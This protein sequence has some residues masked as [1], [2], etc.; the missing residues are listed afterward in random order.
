MWTS[1]LFKPIQ[2]RFRFSIAHGELFAFWVAASA[3]GKSRG[4]LGGGGL[5]FR[6]PCVRRMMSGERDESED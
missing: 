3:A 4:Y 5:G 6:T 2:V 1:R